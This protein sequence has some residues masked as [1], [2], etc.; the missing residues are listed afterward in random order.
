[1][2]RQLQNPAQLTLTTRHINTIGYCPTFFAIT[3]YQIVNEGS[4]Q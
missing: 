3:R 2:R 4:I 1:M